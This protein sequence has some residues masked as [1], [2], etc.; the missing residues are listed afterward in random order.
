MPFSS[1]AREPAA[2]SVPFSGSLPGGPLNYEYRFPTR[3][4]AFWGVALV[5]LAFLPFYGSLAIPFEEPALPPRLFL[6][7]VSL[8]FLLGAGLARRMARATA[9]A[10]FS[11]V[12]RG[13]CIEVPMVDLRAGTVRVHSLPLESL[14]RV[15]D[16]RIP[17]QWKRK[18][19]LVL[20]YAGGSVIIYSSYLRDKGAYEELRGRL[21]T[22]VPR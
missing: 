11:V 21:R 17:R 8:L 20:R 9:G 7:L 19:M 2:S 1:S 6:V 4:A 5:A 16:Q 22:L 10:E 18:R 14:E 12:L 15:V 3:A 13:D